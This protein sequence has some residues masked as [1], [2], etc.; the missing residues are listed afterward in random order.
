MLRATS[1]PPPLNKPDRRS[2]RIRLS[3]NN[4]A[5]GC[6]LLILLSTPLSTAFPRVF[7]FACRH[8]VRC[9]AWTFGGIAIPNRAIASSLAVSF[10]MFKRGPFAPASLPPSSLL[11]ATPTPAGA[12]ASLAFWT[13]ALAPGA[14]TPPTQVSTFKLTACPGIARPSTPP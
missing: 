11:W 5:S 6:R 9:S 10:P 3:E 4:P 8:R 2:Y 13:F 1:P 7:A 12:H 14:F